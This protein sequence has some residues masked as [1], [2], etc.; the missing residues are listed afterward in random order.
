MTPFLHICQ[1]NDSLTGAMYFGRKAALGL[2][3]MPRVEL[4]EGDYRRGTLHSPRRYGKCRLQESMEGEIYSI[5]LPEDLRGSSDLFGE[6]KP[7]LSV[8][9]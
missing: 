2:R 5:V 9:T 3:Q 1:A 8:S 7:P 6:P 4:M